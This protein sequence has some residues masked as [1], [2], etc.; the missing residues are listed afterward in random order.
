[1]MTTDIGGSG[2]RKRKQG[3]EVCIRNV[4]RHMGT[5]EDEI[6]KWQGKIVAREK[7]LVLRKT[8]VASCEMEVEVLRAKVLELQEKAHKAELE[9]CAAKVRE[10]E[11]QACKAQVHA[12][13]A[14]LG[15][16]ANK[17]VTLLA[18]GCKDELEACQK[19]CEACAQK[20]L[21][22]KIREEACH[23][24]CN[25]G[26]VAV[27][28]QEECGAMQVKLLSEERALVIPNTGMVT[29]RDHSRNINSLLL[30]LCKTVTSLEN[31]INGPL[32]G[33]REGIQKAQEV[34]VNPKAHFR[35][36]NVLLMRLWT[37]LFSLEMATDAPLFGVRDGIRQALMIQCKLDG[38]EAV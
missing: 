8:Q 22:W 27:V 15:K 37:Y 30:I 3:V 14:M 32:F 23:A 21:E 2:M 11:L 4:K 9:A 12:Y 17:M 24:S 31:A 35:K 18:S 6:K 33:L 34:L 20:M 13:E 25:G 38:K 36:R 19:E 16:Y 28:Q 1:M 29:T 10:A 5:C 7:D 26:V